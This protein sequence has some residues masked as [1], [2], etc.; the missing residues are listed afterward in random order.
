MEKYEAL[1]T[2][3][4]NA[5]TKGVF[6]TSTVFGFSKDANILLNTPNLKVQSNRLNTSSSKIIRCSNYT[7]RESKIIIP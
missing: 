3:R 4:Q 7:S 6:K 5:I 2:D 1:K